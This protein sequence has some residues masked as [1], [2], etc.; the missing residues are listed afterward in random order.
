MNENGTGIISVL[1]GDKSIKVNIGID[2]LSAAILMFA[3][4]IVGIILIVI[5]KKIK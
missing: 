1:S 3:I 4:F 5:S 2:Y